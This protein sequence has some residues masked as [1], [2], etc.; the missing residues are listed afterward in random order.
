VVAETPKVATAYQLCRDELHRFRAAA[1]EDGV[2]MPAAIRQIVAEFVVRHHV[3]QSFHKRKRER[4]GPDMRGC[5]A[6]G[7]RLA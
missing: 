2:P 4:T 6:A 7:P 5:R 1:G 3:E